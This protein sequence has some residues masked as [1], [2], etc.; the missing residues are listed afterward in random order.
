MQNPSLANPAK[1]STR[2]SAGGNTLPALLNFNTALAVL[3]G[4]DVKEV[5]K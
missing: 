4:F 3:I 2:K 1:F 5:F